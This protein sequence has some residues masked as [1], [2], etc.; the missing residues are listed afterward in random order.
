MLGRC[1]LLLLVGVIAVPLATPQVP[2]TGENSGANAAITQRASGVYRYE[3][4]TEPRRRGEERWQFLAHPDGSRTMIMWNDLAARNAQFTVVLRVAASFRPIDAF[5]SYWNDGKFKGS[6]LFHVD[7]KR[8]MASSF[9]PYGARQQA[10]DVP[11]RFSLGSHPV[12]G[13]GW[14]TWTYDAGVGGAQTC[15]LYALE[16][17]ADLSKPVLGTLQPLTIEKIGPETISVPAGKF[18]TI[19]YR[20]S[21]RND[22]WITPRDRLVIKSVIGDRNLRYELV[23]SA[24]T[25]Q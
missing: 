15:M 2:M 17:S 11:E 18:S 4:I 23:E 3:T 13:D 12:A 14:H 6:A 21:G 5:V 7:G 1:A 22:V 10:I 20:L 25:L 9:G 16:A 8:L 24:G 19:H